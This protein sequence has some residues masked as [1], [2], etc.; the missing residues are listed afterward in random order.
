MMNKE[1]IAIAG[2]EATGSNQPSLNIGDHPHVSNVMDSGWSEAQIER[3]R[4]S[5]RGCG[6]LNVS[7][8]NKICYVI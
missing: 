2:Y 8:E 6:E 7:A 3:D 5:A 1:T 4:K